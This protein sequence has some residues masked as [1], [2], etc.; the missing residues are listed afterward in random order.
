[1]ITDLGRFQPTLRAAGIEAEVLRAP[2]VVSREQ[3]LERIPGAVGI[4]AGD[5]IIDAQIMDAA[6]SLRIIA[7]WGVGLDGVDVEAAAARSIEVANTPGAF[8]DAVADVCLGYLILLAR[9]LH[10]IDRGVRDGK[11]LKPTGWAIQGRVLGI[12]GLGGIGTAFAHRARA[13]GMVVIGTDPSPQ[14]RQVAVASGV[15]VVELEELLATCGVLSLNCPLTPHTRGMIDDAALAR[16]PRGSFLI[17]TS[18]GALVSEPALVNALRS[19]HLAG[20]ALDVFEEEPLPM[21]SELRAFDNVIFGSHNAS[22]AA[23]A[24]RRVSDLAIGNLLR[25]LRASPT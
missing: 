22:N 13:L 14:R 20:A 25:A 16:L 2:Q 23:D 17:N 4:V 18:R 5:E 21:K 15:R 9:Q 8:D 7:R 1:M 10:V 19:V 6:P 12:V 24:A 3:L 11:W